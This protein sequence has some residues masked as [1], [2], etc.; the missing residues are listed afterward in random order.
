MAGPLRSRL[1]RRDGVFLLGFAVGFATGRLIYGSRAGLGFKVLDI[2]PDYSLTV[3]T[4]PAGIAS[5]TGSGAYEASATVSIRTPIAN[6]SGS[7]YH[8]NGW[9]GATVADYS[10]NAT[11]LVMPASAT[12]VTANYIAQQTY[13]N[14]T[15]LNTATGFDDWWM[16]RVFLPLPRLTT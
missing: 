12:T 2:V 3:A 4:N 8:F 10:S 5:T 14:F 11:S 6:Y 1:Q 15:V 9:T 13:E 7:V 16:A